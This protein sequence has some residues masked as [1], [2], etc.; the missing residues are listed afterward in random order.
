MLTI[1]SCDGGYS[2][3]VRIS[4]EAGVVIV[5]WKNIHRLSFDLPYG[6]HF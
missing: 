4:I 3:A 6:S 2:I 1:N 5:Y